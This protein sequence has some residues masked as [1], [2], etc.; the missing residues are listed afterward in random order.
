M[1]DVAKICWNMYKVMFED[2]R[3]RFVHAFT[4]EDTTMRVWLGNRSEMIVS[5]PFNFMKVSIL[6]SAASGV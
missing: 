6:T 3:R 2:P 4:I 5:K 1:Q